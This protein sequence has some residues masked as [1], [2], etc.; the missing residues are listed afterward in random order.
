MTVKSDRAGAVLVCKKCLKRADEGK[1]LK[2]ALKAELKGRGRKDGKR[3]RLIL[4]NCFGLCPKRAVVMASAS[5]LHRSEFLLVS[6][7]NSIPDAADILLR[8]Q[9]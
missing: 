5:T 1:D 7:H 4:T 2:R 9:D 6:D 3:S 8:D